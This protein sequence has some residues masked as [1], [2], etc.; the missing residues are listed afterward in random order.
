VTFAR[1]DEPESDGSDL[2]HARLVAR[3]LDVPLEIA[4]MSAEA[5]LA[6][7]DDVLVRGQDWRDFNVHCGLV[8]AAIASH[9]RQVRGAPDDERPVLLTGDGMNELMADYTPVEYRGREHYGLPKLSP[10]R[11]RRFLTAGL[12]AGDREIG[13]FHAY[14]FDAIQPYAL[15]AP[16]YAAVPD[17]L[18]EIAQAKQQLV[19]HVMGT[20]VPAAIYERPKVRAQVANQEQVGGTMALLL[21]RGIDGD[22]LRAR[23]A[24]LFE[25]SPREVDMLIRGGFYRFSAALPGGEDHVGGEARRSGGRAG[26]VP[27]RGVPDPGR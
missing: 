17:A 6:L 15:C 18:I 9:L 14:G 8:N 16:A 1:D 24:R 19:R 11:L 23:F 25:A 20:R 13:I 7:V 3:E 2:R 10:G 26:A 4:R 12:D 21:D 27:A 5:L 22:A